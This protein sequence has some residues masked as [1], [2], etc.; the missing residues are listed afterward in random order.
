MAVSIKNEETERLARELAKRT[1]VSITEAITT[2]CA[3][4][5]RE[6]KGSAVRRGFATTCWRSADGARRF[7]ISTGAA[8]E[9]FSDTTRLV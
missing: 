6:R 1:G 7:P 2:G 4:S 9:K 5:S 8:R 3:S